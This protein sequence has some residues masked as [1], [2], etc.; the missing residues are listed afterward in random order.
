MEE[1]GCSDP[2]ARVLEPGVFRPYLP[3]SSPPRST[4]AG[5]RTGSF[6]SGTCRWC[7]RSGWHRGT[8]VYLQTPEETAHGCW[9]PASPGSPGATGSR[10]PGVPRVRGTT[11][12]DRRDHVS[13]SFPVHLPPGNLNWKL[14]SFGKP[15]P[16]LSPLLSKEQKRCVAPQGRQEIATKRQ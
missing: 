11:R 9:A 1:P 13:A 12:R 16:L 3:A 14:V 15:A 10:F 5:G 4:S 2:G 8:S 7:S 6:S